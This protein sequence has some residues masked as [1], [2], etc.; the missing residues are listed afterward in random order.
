MAA[1]GIINMEIAAAVD[2]CTEQFILFRVILGK[3]AGADVLPTE[4]LVEWS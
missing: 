4:W 3:G 1:A 2:P